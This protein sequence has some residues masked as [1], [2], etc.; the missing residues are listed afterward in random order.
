[1]RALSTGTGTYVRVPLIFE[2][3]SNG[4][5]MQLNVDMNVPWVVNFIL[6]L[7]K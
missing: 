5:L 6:G 7:P 1:M 2:I 4:K 3:D